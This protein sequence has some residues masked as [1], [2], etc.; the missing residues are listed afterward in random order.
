MNKL[1]GKGKDNLKV[2]NYPL[3]NIMSKLASEE[4]PSQT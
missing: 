2:R 1:T 4:K 3:T